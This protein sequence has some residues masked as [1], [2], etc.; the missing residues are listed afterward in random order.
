MT[1]AQPAPAR[2]LV[3]RPRLLAALDPTARAS[4]TVLSAP[5]GHGRRTLLEQWRARH[6]GMPVVWLTPARGTGRPVWSIGQ[7]RQALDEAAAELV[8]VEDLD[9]VTSPD[10]VRWLRRRS[11]HRPPRPHVVVL[12]ATRWLS[13]GAPGQPTAVRQLSRDQ[14]RFTTEETAELLEL[15]TGSGFDGE[16]VRVLTERSMGWAA[17]LRTVA[18]AAAGAEDAAARLSAFTADDP[19]LVALL[20][21]EILAP[22]PE[23]VQRFLLRSSVL[24][25]LEVAPC[26]AVTGEAASRPMLHLLERRDLFLR[27]TTDVGPIWTYET[28]FRALLRQELRRR[29]RDRETELVDRAVRW[30]LDH[31]RPAPAATC[32]ID[33]QR[34]EDLL[35]VV[36]EHGPRYFE[37]GAAAD[38]LAWLDA[39]PYGPGDVGATELRL[40]R[41]YVLTMLGRSRQAAA[42]VGDLDPDA[43]TPGERVVADTL[44]T[45]WG[46]WHEPPSTVIRISDATLA[47]LD[48][49][50]ASSLPDLCGLTS[51]PSLRLIAAA[52]R[53]RALWYDGDVAAGREAF[54]QVLEVEDAY[55]PWQV[56]ARGAAA[57]AAAWA[58]RLRDARRLAD[59]ALALARSAALLQHPA[60]IDARL[61]MACVARE[62]DE[63][64][65][66]ARALRLVTPIAERTFPMSAM[67][68]ALEQALLAGVRGAPEEGLLLLARAHARLSH[69]IPRGLAGLLR[70]GEASLYLA[71]R[72]VDRARWSLAQ[73]PE[74]P[75]LDAVEVQAAVAAGELDEAR[76]RLAGWQPAPTEPRSCVQHGLWTAAVDVATGARRRG[77]RTAAAAVA[78]AEEEGLVRLVLDGGEPLL[79]LTR[80]LDRT[81]PTPFLRHLVS[82]AE[83]PSASGVRVAFSDRELEVLRK[84]PGPATNPEIAAQLFISVNTLKTHLRTLYRALGAGSR[85]EAVAKAEELGLV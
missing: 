70:A 61:A 7:L 44:R 51:A 23:P 34:W 78:A 2:R 73:D 82:R 57:L 52:Q 4:L 35:E 80:S 64:D 55:P 62:R 40:R 67:L 75:G 8:V 38:L 12:T 46:Y 18:V 29:D 13:G 85:R 14:L 28:P 56:H 50:P 79:R 59:R 42:L 16:H 72:D 24:P 76:E 71:A 47:R 31:D 45:T 41:A 54:A 21:Q 65:R 58:G 1:A 11:A 74:L 53:A 77:L 83:T 20:E 6:P 37:A 17:A 5:A 22:L 25:E 60:T 69:P 84:L 68:G 39:V 36:D 30:Y 27:R 10:A 26:I 81:A 3:D 48:Q 32:L 63:P 9:P 33:A 15:V 19:Y 43:F 66:A 49:L